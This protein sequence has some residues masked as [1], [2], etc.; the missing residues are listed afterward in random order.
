MT[1][2]VDELELTEWEIKPFPS[3]HLAE[4]NILPDGKTELV[5]L[6][7]FFEIEKPILTPVPLEEGILNYMYKLNNL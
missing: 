4:Y 3:G 2:L 6:D 7:Q 5:L 1:Y